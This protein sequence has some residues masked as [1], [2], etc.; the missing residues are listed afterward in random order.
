ML[1]A[2]GRLG[3]R[4]LGLPYCPPYCPVLSP[5]LLSPLSSLFCGGVMHLFVRVLSDNGAKHEATSNKQRSS[6]ILVASA[7]S[8]AKS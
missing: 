3:V 4:G 2:F 8:A 5:T 7:E 1:L 6:L